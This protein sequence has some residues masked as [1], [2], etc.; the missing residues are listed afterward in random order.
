MTITNILLTVVVL[1]IAG[2]AIFYYIKKQKEEQVET[3]NVRALCSIA[4]YVAIATVD[5]VFPV[6]FFCSF[7]NVIIAI[8]YTPFSIIFTILLTPESVD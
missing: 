4:I 6:C 3:I 7:Q 2:L 5:I 8:T 1:I